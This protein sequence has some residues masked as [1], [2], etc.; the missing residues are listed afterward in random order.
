MVELKAITRG[1]AALRTGRDF[2][3][4]TVV[5]THGSSYRQPG[6]RMLIE[7]GAS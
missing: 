4:A 7:L 1:A 5:R 2:L 3:R 6:A